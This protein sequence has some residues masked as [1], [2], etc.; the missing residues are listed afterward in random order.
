MKVS[1]NLI[2]EYAG[3]ALRVNGDTV[4]ASSLK[5]AP[6]RWIES[7]QHIKCETSSRLSHNLYISFCLVCKS[8]TDYSRRMWL[9]TVKCWNKDFHQVIWYL[10]IFINYVMLT[11]SK[12]IIIMNQHLKQ[13]HCK[14]DSYSQMYNI[15]LKVGCIQVGIM[16]NYPRFLH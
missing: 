8:T 11:I 7:P 1:Q 9:N 14:P 13:Q 4:T 16:Y 6:I 15:V 10:C 5:G 2:A 3:N 12:R